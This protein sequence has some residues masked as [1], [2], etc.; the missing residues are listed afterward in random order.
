M[1]ELLDQSKKPNGGDVALIMSSC[2]LKSVYFD[3]GVTHKKTLS[4][5]E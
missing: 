1:P 4:R 3:V 5:L 2:L